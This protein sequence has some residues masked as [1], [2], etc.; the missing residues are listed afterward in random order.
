M[1]GFELWLG[2]WLVLGL[3]LEYN[4]RGLIC[5][6]EPSRERVKVSHVIVECRVFNNHPTYYPTVPKERKYEK[7][8]DNKKLMTIC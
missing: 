6:S 5:P 2:F 7:R 3:G 8:I 4:A 1:L